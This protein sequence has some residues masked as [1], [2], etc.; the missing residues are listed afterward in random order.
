MS[1]PDLD[2]DTKL[3]KYLVACYLSD[4]DGLISPFSQTQCK[5]IWANGG[6]WTDAS[7]KPWSKVFMLSYLDHVFKA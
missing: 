5:T 1:C 4:G 2:E 6:T 7:G 3:G